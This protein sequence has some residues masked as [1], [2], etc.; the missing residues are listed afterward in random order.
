MSLL[1][2]SLSI[3][4]IFCTALVLGQSDPDHKNFLEIGL[5]PYGQTSGP[6][7]LAST[8]GLD[9]LIYD[10]GMFGKATYSRSFDVVHLGLQVGYGFFPKN[11]LAVSNRRWQYTS[12]MLQ[13]EMIG[14]FYIFNNQ[15]NQIAIQ[16]SGG[17]HYVWTKYINL[18]NNYPTRENAA[19][20][21]YGAGLY[22]KK[23][24][25][26]DLSPWGL[27]YRNVGGLHF[28]SLSVNVPLVS[29]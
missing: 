22:A 6:F 20:Y 14:R 27:F 18:L 15:R 19:K 9:T 26:F 13:T 23:L 2:K 25:G 21:S 16:A 11:N 28:M 29:W 12:H 10:W 1:K 3:T 24:F 5:E 17:M 4:C 8:G 7:G